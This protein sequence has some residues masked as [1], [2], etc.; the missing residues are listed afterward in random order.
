MHYY[1]T[2]I[3]LIL[4]LSISACLNTNTDTDT[5]APQITLNAPQIADTNQL[6]SGTILPIEV[7]FSDN[8]D[9]LAYE[10]TIR[11]STQSLDNAWQSN[12]TANLIGNNAQVNT[13]IAIPI[14]ALTA[15]YQLEIHGLDA[16]NNPSNTIIALLNVQNATDTQVPNLSLL[17]PSNTAITV[18]G[19]NNLVVVAELT[20]NQKL[21]RY[22]MQ[23]HK[24]N[25]P[26]PIYQ[27]LP[28]ALD[29]TY[30]MLQEII[31]MPN[32]SGNYRL[33]IITSD[34]VNNTSRNNL[35]I[36]VL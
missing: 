17:L 32:E 10:Y 33:E 35:N 22:Y 6:Y 28:I 3:C 8:Q 14:D 24:N 15:L 12:F 21:H 11:E 19:G 5:E 4:L 18:F 2:S 36:T 13:Q 1:Y 20:D 34:A 25:S 7:L 31:P 23:L 30:Y 16:N 27:S 9:L 26:Q 29:S